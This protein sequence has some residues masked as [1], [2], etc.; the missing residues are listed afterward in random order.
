MTTLYV[1]DVPAEVAQRLKERAAAE[2][3][4]LSA[5]VVAELGRIASRPT[6]AEMVQRLRDLDRGEGPTSGDI[7]QALAQSRR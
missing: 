5:Y 1:R 2:G 3:K 6:N 4:S 7:V